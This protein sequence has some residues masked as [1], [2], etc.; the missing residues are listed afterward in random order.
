MLRS[1]GLMLLASVALT[2]SA[3]E[4]DMHSVCLQCLH[5]RL[6]VYMQQAASLC[7]SPC[8]FVWVDTSVCA[9]AFVQS[10]MLMMQAAS[11][12]HERHV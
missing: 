7:K 11:N 8:F 5:T 10:C 9:H 6:L 4:V 1:A 2:F 12:V 3:Y